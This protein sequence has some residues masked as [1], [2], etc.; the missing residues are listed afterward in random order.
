MQWEC[1]IACP[2]SEAC[3]KSR[4]FIACRGQVT[5]HF[6]EFC[7]SC[8]Y[9]TSVFDYGC[10]LV[11]LYCLYDTKWSKVISSTI[12]SAIV[13][14]N[15]AAH[16]SS[17]GKVMSGCGAN[18]DFPNKKLTSVWPCWS[19][20]FRYPTATMA[21]ADA[22]AITQSSLLFYSSDIRQ[23]NGCANTWYLKLCQILK[24]IFP[25]SPL[26]LPLA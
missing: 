3:V 22:S 14:A 6:V 19:V 4:Q 13:T 1:L 11:L 16:N 15:T 10:C 12:N 17:I 20:T 23:R 21:V 25:F 18:L 8:G 5:W 7:C 2:V 9:K 24:R 26:E